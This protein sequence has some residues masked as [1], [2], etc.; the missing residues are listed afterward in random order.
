VLSIHPAI[1]AWLTYIIKPAQLCGRGIFAEHR[2]DDD[3][4]VIRRNIHG[5]TCFSQLGWL[6]VIFNRRATSYFENPRQAPKKSCPP[7]RA[8]LD[9]RREPFKDSTTYP[10][11]LARQEIRRASCTMLSA[12][13]RLV[14]FDSAIQARQSRVAIRKRRHRQEI[15]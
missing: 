12:R 8:P 7:W 2:G 4:S 10:R 11:A 9:S 15:A 3:Q 14:E 1:Y 13:Q 6:F 5:A